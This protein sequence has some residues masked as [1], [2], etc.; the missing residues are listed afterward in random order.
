MSK[1][2]PN[3]LEKISFDFIGFSTTKII[4]YSITFAQ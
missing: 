4:Q 3:S 2:H 1:A